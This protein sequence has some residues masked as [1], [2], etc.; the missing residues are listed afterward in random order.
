[1]SIFNNALKNEGDHLL[2]LVIESE[3][4]IVNS[5]PKVTRKAYFDGSQMWHQIVL[6]GGSECW[7]TFNR[8]ENPNSLPYN[9]SSNIEAIDSRV[10]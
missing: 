8:S 6:N 7:L 3:P 10:K 1:M 9:I 5:N 4:E 2:K